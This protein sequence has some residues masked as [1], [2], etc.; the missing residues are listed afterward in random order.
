MLIR[1]VVAGF[2]FVVGLALVTAWRDVWADLTVT[3]TGA[4]GCTT[5]EST[6]FSAVPIAMMVAAAGIAIATVLWGMPDR[7]EGD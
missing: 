3:I 7:G 1:L 2:T 5:F 6:L 4:P